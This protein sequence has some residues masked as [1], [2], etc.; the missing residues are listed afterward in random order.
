[1][2]IPLSWLR[3]YVRVDLA[4]E[5][6]AHRLTMAGTEVGAIERT[7]DWSNVVV[8]LVKQ[9]KPHPDADR[10][11]LVTVYNGDSEVEVVCG[12]P[13]VA[14]GQKIAYASVGAELIDGH[15]GK[16]SK[17]KRSKIRGVVSEGMVCSEKE[18]GLGESHEG[19]LVLDPDA[20]TGTPLGDVI[21]E[22]ILD[23]ELT[24]NRPD[25][26]GVLGIAREVA[27]LTGAQLVE[28]PIDYEQAGQSVDSLAKVVIEAPDLC[29]R[30]TASV[31]SGIK[32]GPSPQWLAGRLRAVGERPIN[33]VVDVTNYVM[34][35]M[36]QPLHAFDF[37]KVV[38]KTVL[39]RRAN[40]GEVLVTLDDRE[41]RLNNDMLVIADRQRAIGLAGVM[42]GAN[43]EISD[44]TTTVFLES[45]TFDGSNN[46]R[47]ARGLG[48]A[49]QATLRF[50]KGLRAGL[51]GVALRRATRLILQVAGG[52]ASKRILD[53][54]PGEG[55]E[56]EAVRLDRERVSRVLGV[57]LPDDKVTGTLESLGFGVQQAEDGWRVTVPYW[58]PDIAIQEDLC[59]ELAR[60][61][62]Y[63]SIP[64]RTLSGRIPAW[65]PQPEL[66]LRNRVS[67][68]LTRAGMQET[69]SYSATTV[70]GEDRVRLPGATPE[71]LR[72]KNP[73]SAEHVVMRRTLREAVLRSLAH[74]VRV[75]RGPI[76]LF[77]SGRVFLDHG[78]GLPEE[79]Q[80]VAGALTGP[81]SDPHWS[82]EQGDMDFFD[83]KG[84][85]EAVLSDLNVE[86]DFTPTEDATFITGRV[87][88]ITAPQAGGV[89]LGVVGE[90]HP[91]VLAAFD[92]D[93]SPVAMFE[94]SLEA[95]AS[96]VAGK[97]AASSYRPFTRL[98]ESP[99]DLALL[100]DSG[101][102]AGDVV[103]IASRN[104][105]V[106]SATVFDVYEGRG[107]P[108]G[109]KSLAIRI[110]Y[111][112]ANRTLTAEEVG[113]AEQSILRA[114]SKELGAE[115]RT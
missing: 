40:P 2:R 67:D 81:R 90:V 65:A 29:P 5:D 87:A 113:K 53:H 112:S 7:G 101:V 20:E 55:D 63:D 36:G 78:E 99:R 61:I 109:K 47:T 32:I 6:L 57:D 11:R 106:T 93:V 54:W 79:K 68:V 64:T 102:P 74:N 73:I 56:V 48:L 115:L 69:I 70:E 111:Q 42:G 44:A 72:I 82:V 21:G 83:A 108:A 22:T 35:E 43:T 77:E 110:V 98:P 84:M 23:L 59:E 45:A 41:R 24:P 15:T 86:A 26:L 107:V 14:E 10:L 4:P 17:L 104:R 51:S 58:R 9:V 100:L 94:L 60:T 96:A 28:P 12:A 50:E 114:L 95:L 49:S 37:D 71:H 89:Q 39:V 80:M 13:N 103:K 75:W 88:A 8:G 76:A 34:F 25:C 92:T 30:Y 33:N 66:S 18:L 85:V 105:L 1:M 31:I 16:P 52:S 3:E 91:D 19:I 97:P 46:R 38:D 62:G 27:A